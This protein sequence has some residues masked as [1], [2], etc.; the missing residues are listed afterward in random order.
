PSSCVAREE[1]RRQ[2]LRF[3]I[4]ARL[5][6]SNP[7]ATLRDAILSC[8][9]S[10]VVQI[11]WSHWAGEKLVLTE[12]EGRFRD[13]CFC[14]AGWNDVASERSLSPPCEFWCC[15]FLPPRRG[16]NRKAQGNALGILF[17]KWVPAFKTRENK[18]FARFL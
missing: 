16:R 17:W 5:A 12:L 4:P 13:T 6:G 11:P 8:P 15:A 2:G 3:M 14:C 18:H 1:S 10:V 9:L 7:M